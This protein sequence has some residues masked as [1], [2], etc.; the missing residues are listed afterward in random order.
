MERR[1]VTFFIL[2]FLILS[3]WSWF[4]PPQR[5][6]PPKDHA[7]AVAKAKP[8]GDQK[9]PAAVEKPSAEKPAT[10]SAAKPQPAAMAAAISPEPET[11]EQWITLG[12][13]DPKDPYRMLVTLTNRGAALQRIEL[14]SP[15]YCDVDDRRGYLGHLVADE[16]SHDGKCV[17]QVVGPGT[18]A[19]EAG[20]RPG[21]VIKSVRGKAVSNRRSLDA[22]LNKTRPKQKIEIVVVRDGKEMSLS[23]VLRRRPLEVVQPES[24]APLSMLLTLQQFGDEKIAV[25]PPTDEAATRVQDESETD[26]AVRKE[27]LYNEFLRRE[28]D[29]VKLRTANWRIAS[30]DQT[31]VQFRRTLPEKGLEITKTYRL[32]N[33][34]EKAL[35][36]ASFPAYHLEFEVEIR[37]IGAEACKAAYRLDGPN[38]LPTEGSWYATRV[39]RTGGSGVR[40]LVISLGNVSQTVGAMSV[41]SGKIPPPWPDKPDRPLR[42]IGVD[43]QYFSAVLLPRR[44]GEDGAWFDAMLPI[45]V[46]KFNSRYPNLANTSCRL[47]GA[48]SELEPGDAIVNQFKLF[49]GP[50][51]AAILENKEYGLGDLIYFGWP[52]F[53]LF[54]VPL[55]A[56]LHSFYSVVP[57]YGIAIV[58]LTVFV[59][60]L[61]FPISRKQALSMKK[62]Q[63]LQPEIK[64]IQEKFK[65]NVEA[66]TKAQQELFRKHNYNP[67]SGCLPMFIQLP[68]FMGLYRAL[69]V[70]IELRD[71]PLINHSI[72]WCSNLSAPDMLFNWTPL[73]PEYIS[74]GMNGVFSLGPFFNVLP[75]VSVILIIAQQKMFMPPATDEQTAMQQK[76]MQYMMVF[77]GVM[78]FKVASG[79]CIYFIVQSLLAFVER[80]FLP[81]A[82][83]VAAAPETRADAKARE[84]QTAK[85]KG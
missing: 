70:A 28:L 73:M 71:A 42:Y 64:K 9:E 56:I 53:A 29:G 31:Q 44:G 55:T 50:K 18:P 57:N 74:S 19:A 51:K 82:V 35:A 2:A 36:D 85:G 1:L 76:V 68:V 46:G 59:R 52:I 37:N 30:A 22:A 12:S 63:E 33:V 58:L 84:R 43:A 39:T 48:V 10:E 72:R 24:D 61:M 7:A 65:S 21:D 80:K 77:M 45:R 26:A 4:F 6:K 20:I 23:A 14:N 40:D 78:F 69:M 5:P 3:S 32:A 38:G 17:V 83:P 60:G 34:P 47:I 66:R 75:V 62:M 8:P 15:R 79:L 54:A 81:K 27:N 67:L 13:A 11:P 25:A 16:T 49:A 41:A